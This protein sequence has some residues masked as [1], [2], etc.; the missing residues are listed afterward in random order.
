MADDKGDVSIE[1]FNHV[2]EKLG[3]RRDL[4]RLER[5]RGRPAVQVTLE[6]PRMDIDA[7]PDDDA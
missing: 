4:S 1:L 7:N 5:K 3:P 6:V 2:G